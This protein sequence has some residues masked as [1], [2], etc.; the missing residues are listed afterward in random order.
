[1]AIGKGST[2]FRF[3]SIL[4]VTMLISAASGNADAETTQIN[5]GIDSKVS[6]FLTQARQSWSD[7][8]VPYNDGKRLY[9]LVVKGN[10]KH[11][12]EIGTSTGHSTIWLA[13]AASKTGGVVVTIEIDKER[14]LKALDNF[15]QAGVDR[16]IDARLTDAHELVPVLMGPFDFV[17]CDAD[18]EWYLQYFKEV[19]NKIAPSGCFVA[20][21]VLWRGSPEID[22]FLSYVESHPKFQT[23]IEKTSSEGIS[24]SCR[25]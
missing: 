4:V 16:F 7:L 23:R 3:L 24:V 14:Y 8:N 19:E 17:F 6:R 18:K 15:K 9:D 10:F 20:H 22:R 2:V 21:N 12:L 25:K 11:I 1:M 5:S 13:W